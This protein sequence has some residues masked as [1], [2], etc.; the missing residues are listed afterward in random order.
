MG[1]KDNEL[2]N[3]HTHF[4]LLGENEDEAKEIGKVPNRYFWGDES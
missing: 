1:R 4:V 2:T 3:G